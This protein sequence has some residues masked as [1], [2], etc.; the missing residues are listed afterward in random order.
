MASTYIISKFT[1]PDGSTCTIKEPDAATH[2]KAG[3][4]SAADKTKLDALASGKAPVN[5][6]DTG[7]I[8][9]IIK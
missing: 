6:L 8:I 2:D 4:M 9:T 5:I 1:L 7:E 3:L